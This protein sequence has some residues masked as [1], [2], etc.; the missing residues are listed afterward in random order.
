MIKYRGIARRNDRLVHVLDPG[1]HYAL[2]KTAS[3]LVDGFSEVYAVYVGSTDSEHDAANWFFG[4]DVETVYDQQ[5]EQDPYGEERK[6]PS[7]RREGK[8]I[9]DERWEYGRGKRSDN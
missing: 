2:Y 4:Y 9:H 1:C 8:A 3:L 5:D 6:R 7:S